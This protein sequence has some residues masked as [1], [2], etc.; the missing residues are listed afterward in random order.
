MTPEAIR[1]LIYI[2]SIP[3]VVLVGAGILIV[4]AVKKK[5]RR[6]ERDEELRP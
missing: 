1:L 6:Q 5:K 3:V 2:W 4:S